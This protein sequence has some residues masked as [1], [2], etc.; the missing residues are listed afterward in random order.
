M[1]IFKYIYNYYFSRKFWVER[2][3]KLDSK[4]GWF[5]GRTDMI[6]YDWNGK[7]VHYAYPGT[8]GDKRVGFNGNFVSALRKAVLFAE[9]KNK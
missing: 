4:R 5:V 2:A 3:D 9:S 8:D 7:I 6:S 1:K